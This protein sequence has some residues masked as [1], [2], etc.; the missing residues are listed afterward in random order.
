MTNVA[1]F[2]RQNT[3]VYMWINIIVSVII[4]LWFSMYAYFKVKLSG[5]N[6]RIEYHSDSSNRWHDIAIDRDAKIARL[7]DGMNLLAK[8]KLALEKELKTRENVYEGQIKNLNARLTQATNENRKFAIESAL[9]L[10]RSSNEDI[11]FD[12]HYRE[13]Y[14]FLQGK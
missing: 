8:E 12:R 11:S 9:K 10:I 1:E 2:L 14:K 4:V 13:I 3:E 6:S 7:T 5:K